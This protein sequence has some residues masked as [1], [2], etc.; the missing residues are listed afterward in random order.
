[1]K[2]PGIAEHSL[3]E[4]KERVTDVE[5]ELA[6]SVVDGRAIFVFEYIED[7]PS[8]EWVGMV[9]HRPF[10]ISEYCPIHH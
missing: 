10:R 6:V 1:M 7:V 2:A 3:G 8:T 4:R 9:S 5:V